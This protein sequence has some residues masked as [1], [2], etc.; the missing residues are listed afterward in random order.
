MLMVQT[1]CC[2]H[3]LRRGGRVFFTDINEEEGRAA[4]ADME[5]DTGASVGFCVQV[6]LVQGDACVS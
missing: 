5:A 1:L 4:R 6:R 3:A 2:R